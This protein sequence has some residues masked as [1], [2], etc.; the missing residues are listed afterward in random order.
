MD[1][2]KITVPNVYQ[3]NE[4]GMYKITHEETIFFPVGY[5]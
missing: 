1:Q 2:A 3:P 4:L 5:W